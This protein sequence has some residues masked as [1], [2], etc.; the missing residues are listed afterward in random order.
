[1]SGKLEDILKLAQE[2]KLSYEMSLNGKTHSLD[3]VKIKKVE[4]PVNKPT[5]RGGIYYSDKTSYKLIGTLYDTS[6]ISHLS[7]KMLG[8]NT[9]F[10]ELKVV[11]KTTPNEGQNFSIFANLTNYMQAKSRIELNMTITRV[12]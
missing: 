6:V 7:K 5:M 9:E 3:S 8:P 4:T 2:E 11:A 12:E 1:M 10:E